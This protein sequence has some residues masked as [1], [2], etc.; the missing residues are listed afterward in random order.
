MKEVKIY[1]VRRNGKVALETM[2]HDEALTWAT[3]WFNED[4]AA[5]GNR[6]EAPELYEY[7]RVPVDH[8]G[9]KESAADE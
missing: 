1:Q 3:S 7:E 2:S 5:M 8:T 9:E 4:R 6:A